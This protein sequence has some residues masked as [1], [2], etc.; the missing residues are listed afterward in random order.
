M[1][2]FRLYGTIFFFSG[3]EVEF[4]TDE[5]SVSEVLILLTIWLLIRKWSPNLII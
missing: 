2:I 3:N 1:F 5:K 4:I